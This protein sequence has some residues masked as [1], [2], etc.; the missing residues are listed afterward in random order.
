MKTSSV[1]KRHVVSHAGAFAA[2]IS[3][4]LMFTGLFSGRDLRADF[5]RVKPGMSR[6]EA[7]SIVG[8]LQESRHQDNLRCAWWIEEHIAVGEISFDEV[9][10]VSSV[11]IHDYP[12]LRSRVE[13]ARDQL[14]WR[15]QWGPPDRSKN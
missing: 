4:S 8:K 14:P 10:R 6:A 2:G 5:G 15:R 7:E 1:L 3:L 12:D 13:K 11:F 9:N